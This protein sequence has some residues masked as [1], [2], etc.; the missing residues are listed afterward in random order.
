MPRPVIQMQ[1]VGW[2]GHWV[3]E[4]VTKAKPEEFSI[5]RFRYLFGAYPLP[6]S[7]VARDFENYV[8]QI[9]AITSPTSRSLPDGEN[10]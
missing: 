9:S 8:D 6:M 4:G 1:K 10:L 5:D 7:H 3:L 2:L